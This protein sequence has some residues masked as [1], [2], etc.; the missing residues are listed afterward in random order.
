[1]FLRNLFFKVTSCLISFKSPRWSPRTIRPE[2]AQ[3]SQDFWAAIRVCEGELE[4]GDRYLWA[5]GCCLWTSDWTGARMFEIVNKTNDKMIW[6]KHW[7]DWQ[8]FQNNWPFSMSAFFFFNPSKI[9]LPGLEETCSSSLEG[10]QTLPANA[11]LPWQTIGWG[12]P[13]RFNLSIHLPTSWV[14]SII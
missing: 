1:M 14:T 10:K 5:L 9:L 6:K 12:I 13:H 7:I 3:W 4:N 2:E 11:T 8:N